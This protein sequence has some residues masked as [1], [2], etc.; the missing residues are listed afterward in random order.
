MND[1]VE[2]SMEDEDKISDYLYEFTQGYAECILWANTHEMTTEGDYTE[3][4]IEPAWWQDNSGQWA[5]EAF[6]SE[7]AWS[8]RLVCED[9]IRSNWDDLQAITDKRPAEY[10]GHDFALTRNGHGT[11]FWDRGL[12]DIGDRLTTNS[13]PYGESM[14]YVMADDVESG[15]SKA[16]LDSIEYR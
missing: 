16:H 12:G 8:I 15:D 11:G 13:K 14:A 10:A 7:S 1:T 3:T 4:V 9:F 5:V 2:F 6:D